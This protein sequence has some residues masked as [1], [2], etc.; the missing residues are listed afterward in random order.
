MTVETA[1]KPHEHD[2]NGDHEQDHESQ[3]EED[4]KGQTR[5]EKKARKAM[6]KL[7]LKP[8]PGVTRVTMRRSKHVSL[9][10]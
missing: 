3:E 4:S 5:T 9:F 10:F 8:V 6:A 1:Q 7:G 2:E